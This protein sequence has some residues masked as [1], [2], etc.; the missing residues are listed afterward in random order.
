MQRQHNNNTT[1]TKAVGREVSARCPCRWVK[2]EDRGEARSEKRDGKAGR[3]HTRADTNDERV[4]GTTGPTSVSAAS[5]ATSNPP[6]LNFFT[7][8]V[9]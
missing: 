3:Q 5:I 6:Q 2:K 9:M 7:L 8:T 1:K 4:D